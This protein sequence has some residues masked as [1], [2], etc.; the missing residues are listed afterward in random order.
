MPKTLAMHELSHAHIKERLDALGLDLKVVTFGKDGRYMIDGTPTPP[1]EAE[2]D[3]L[4]LSQHLNREGAFPATIELALA[5]KSIGV[6]QTFN[7]GLDNPFYGKMSRKGVRILNSSAQ[8]IAIAE[9]VFG[10][11]LAVLQP[12]A[13]QRRMQAAKEWRVTRFRE[14]SRTHWLIAGYGPIGSAVASRAKAFGAGVSVLRRSPTPAEHADRTGALSDAA[15]FAAD[16]DI[17]VLACPLNDVTRGMADAAFFEA[18]K[19]GAILVNIARG[20]LI[21]DAALIAALDAERLE[22]AILDVF[23]TEPLPENDPLWTHPKVR[24]TPHTS[25]GGDGVQGRWDALFLENIQRFAAD[26]PLLQEVDPK[27]II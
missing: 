26:R 7:A 24:A 13:E 20:G 1:E 10:Q 23:H 15:A 22:T 16:A 6:M 19:P 18:A 4:W 17:I 3:Y 11:V 25:F 14:I 5:T 2:I 8:G 9:Y 12:I 21:D 27:D